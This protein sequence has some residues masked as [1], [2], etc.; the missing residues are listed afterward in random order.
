MTSFHAM[1]HRAPVSAGDDVVIHGC[2]GIGL[3]A[4]HIAN[5]LGGNVIGV[6]LMDEK[7]TRPR[8]SVLS[9]LSTLGR[10]TMPRPKST[11]SPTVARTFRPMRWVLQPPAGTR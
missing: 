10:S 4:V 7:L 1:A 5:A 8:N 6:D 2:G 3:S 11:I 9:T